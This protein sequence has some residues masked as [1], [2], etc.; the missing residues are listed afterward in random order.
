MGYLK[1]YLLTSGYSRWSEVWKTRGT[2]YQ[3]T[4][5]ASQLSATPRKF[6]R[7]VLT[8]NIWRFRWQ[9]ES[10]KWEQSSTRQWRRFC[11]VFAFRYCRFCCV[12]FRVAPTSNSWIT[13]MVPTRLVSAPVERFSKDLVE[14]MYRFTRLD[15]LNFNEHYAVRVSIG[16]T[17][18]IAIGYVE[19]LTSKPCVK[20]CGVSHSTGK[21]IL[22]VVYHSFVTTWTGF[23]MFGVVYHM[24]VGLSRTPVADWIP[25]SFIVFASHYGQGKLSMTRQLKRCGEKSS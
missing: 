19:V 18:H 1:V 17:I 10:I 4:Y 3:N 8:L 15:Y 22:V 14:D 21:R 7:K 16:Y 25:V 13:S 20:T 12:F 11:L 2:C 23:V 6:P 9:R 24:M 5:Y